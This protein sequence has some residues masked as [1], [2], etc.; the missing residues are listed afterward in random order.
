[1]E[2]LDIIKQKIR[3][4]YHHEYQLDVTE[5]C[6]KVQK[7]L[8]ERQLTPNDLVI[9]DIDDTIFSTY[10]FYEQ[11]DFSRFKHP[12]DLSLTV[13]PP[14]Q[15]IIDLYFYILTLGINVILMTGRYEMFREHTV[16]EL[17]KYNILAKTPYNNGYLTLIMREN[18]NKEPGSS[19]KYR[20]RKSLSRNYQ[21][22]ANVGDQDSDFYGGHNGYIVKLPNYMY[23]IK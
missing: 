2:N 22:V 1:M 5:I 8:N 17:T 9:F 7:Y 13:L 3:H 4:Y 20:H 10:P 21:I 18:E 14:I 6:N 15:P 12:A 11:R 16:N 19:F 23:Y